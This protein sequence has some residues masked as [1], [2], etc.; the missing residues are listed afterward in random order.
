MTCRRRLVIHDPLSGSREGAYGQLAGA[1]EALNDAQVID[2][3]GGKQEGGRVG[4]TY[5]HCSD[6]NHLVHA[7]MIRV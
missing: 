6:M 7:A 4:V 3:H 1:P 5:L 2:R